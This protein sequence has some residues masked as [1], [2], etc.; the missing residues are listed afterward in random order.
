MALKDRVAEHTSVDS[1]CSLGR[2][3]DELDGDELAALK[4]MLGTPD[5]WGWTAP[6]IYEALK[7]EGY[8]V[9]FKVINKHRGGKCQSSRGAA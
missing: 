3:L 2:L 4:V 1:C 8:A 6:E 7:L 9:G 5:A